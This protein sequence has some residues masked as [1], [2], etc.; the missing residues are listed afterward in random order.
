MSFEQQ[1]DFLL[2][3]APLSIVLT[4]SVLGALPTTHVPEPH[5]SRY[6]RPGHGCST[7]MSLHPVL[8]HPSSNHSLRLIVR[9]CFLPGCSLER[10]TV[11]C[12]ISRTVVLTITNTAQTR[13]KHHLSDMPY[14]VL[15]VSTRQ[16]Q[17]QPQQAQAKETKKLHP[18]VSEVCSHVF[19]YYVGTLVFSAV[20]ILLQASQHARELVLERRNAKSR[21]LRY[22]VRSTLPRSSVGV[23]SSGTLPTLREASQLDDL[24]L[25]TYYLLLTT[26]NLL[27]TTR[28]ASWTTY[29]LL[30]STYYLLLTTRRASWATYQ[31]LPITYYLLLT[32]RR[33]NQTTYYL[34]LTTYYLLL[35]TYCLLLTTYYLLLTSRRASWTTYYLLPTTYYL[36]LT[37]RRADWTTYYLLLT[38]YYLL[39][40]TYY[41]L[42]APYYL[43]LTTYYLPRTTYYLLLT[44]YN[45]LLTTHYSLLTAYY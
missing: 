4:L 33:A 43:L 1:E 16:Q 44:T 37:I 26:H 5:R 15:L 8:P 12:Q 9:H 29:Y 41:L 31:S 32:N 40:T 34:L 28:R 23:E 19:S 39:L 21:R 42:L 11:T 2:S 20:L 36:L 18:Y 27:L 7:L 10:V 17:N 45:L 14:D 25:T 30:P 24:L 22:R 38:T 6:L 13:H 35:T 3:T